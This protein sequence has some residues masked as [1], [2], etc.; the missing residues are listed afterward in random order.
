MKCGVTTQLVPDA[1]FI[2][3]QVVCCTAC[4][5]RQM[6][7]RDRINIVHFPDNIGLKLNDI[8]YWHSCVK[9]GSKHIVVPNHVIQPPHKVRCPNPNR[10]RAKQKERV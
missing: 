8:V 9:C 6:V 2:Q 5:H 4:N 10:P 3:L 1:N 7:R